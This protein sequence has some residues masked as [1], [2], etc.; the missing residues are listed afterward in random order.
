MHM[1]T[2]TYTHRHTHT[3]THRHMHTHAQTRKH[4]RAHTNTHTYTHTH[5]C[6]HTCTHAH[7]PR[8][9]ARGRGLAPGG[10]SHRALPADS[11]LKHAP[12]RPNLFPRRADASAPQPM[13][14]RRA[15]PAPA[16]EPVTSIQVL[17]R[18]AE[19]LER[20][21]RG[22]A[23]PRHARGLA[24]AEHGYASVCPAQPRQAVG[25]VR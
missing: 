22:A 21:E 4:T 18:A 17:L 14:A 19:F 2:D 25:S 12:S 20:R 9:W 15:G 23:R 16:M 10:V 6:T 5:T 13:G 8:V 24:A 3:Q 1:H 7:A 11:N